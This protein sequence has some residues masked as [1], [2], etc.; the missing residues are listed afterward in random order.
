MLTVS[1]GVAIRYDDYYYSYIPMIVIVSQS[2]INAV[3]NNLNLFLQASSTIWFNESKFW[4]FTC[5]CSK[6]SVLLGWNLYLL[7]TAQVRFTIYQL[8]LN[9]S[10]HVHVCMYCLGFQTPLLVDYR[11]RGVLYI[12][13]YV[14]YSCISAL[15][16]RCDMA[17]SW[18]LNNLW[19]FSPSFFQ[20]TIEF[21]NNQTN[22]I[23]AR[24]RG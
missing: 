15:M 10:D 23:N 22:R 21:Y 18:F 14:D 8:G 16:L 3:G 19:L 20:T 2:I 7:C 17:I 1:V 13:F 4:P 12:S 9:S 11:Q 24:N 6:T 5:C